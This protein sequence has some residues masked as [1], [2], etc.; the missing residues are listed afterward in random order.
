MDNHVYHGDRRSM[1]SEFCVLMVAGAK[2][3]GSSKIERIDPPNCAKQWL[4]ELAKSL[5]GLKGVDAKLDGIWMSRRGQQVLAYNST[6]KPATAEIDS[7]TVQIAP[8]SIYV[9]PEQN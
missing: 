2:W 5:R 7:K 4:P 6:D 3:E 8:N 1:L 9:K